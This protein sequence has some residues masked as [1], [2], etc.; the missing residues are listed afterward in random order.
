MS[1]AILTVYNARELSIAMLSFFRFTKSPEW[2]KKN[3]DDE[4]DL[5]RQFD[6]D[7]VIDGIKCN[8]MEL[9]YEGLENIR[10]LHSLKTFSLKNVKQFDDWCLDRIAGNQFENLEELDISGTSITANG[11]VA[12]P[13]LQSLKVLIVS[14]VKRSP[15]FELSLLMLEDILPGLKILEAEKTVEVTEQ[16][17]QQ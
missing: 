7:W 15:A 14:D 8:G 17:P 10:R 13:K 9:F 12:V 4:F 5:P 1:M 11:L 6:P 3:E 16:K 2:V